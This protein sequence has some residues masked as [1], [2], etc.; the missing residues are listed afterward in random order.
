LTDSAKDSKTIG[1]YPNPGNGNIYLNTNDSAVKI[2]K[3]SVFN[4]LG[5]E[6]YSENIENFQTPS[7]FNLS[8]LH[9]GIY[10]FVARN[11]QS[12]IVFTS[13]FIIKK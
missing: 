11:E 3:V 10:V 9:N 6:M 4:L 2:N 13:R 1:I 5:K 12:E 8:F 7:H